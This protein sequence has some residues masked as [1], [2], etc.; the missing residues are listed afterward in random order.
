MAALTHWLQVAATLLLSDV[1]DLKA[2]AKLASGDPH[3]FNLGT[4][5][6]G[7]NICGQ[8]LRG[9]QFTGIDSAA[10]LFDDLTE[11]DK[12]YWR[13]FYKNPNAVQLLSQGREI[14]ADFEALQ[15]EAV[16]IISTIVRERYAVDRG[17]KLFRAILDNRQVGTL[18][19]FNYPVGRSATEAKAVATL[20]YVIEGHT[21]DDDAAC[22]S[23]NKREHS[24]NIF[25]QRC[26]G[27]FLVRLLA[28]LL[29]FPHKIGFARLWRFEQCD[30][31]RCDHKGIV[32]YHAQIFAV[33]AALACASPGDTHFAM[34]RHHPEIRRALVLSFVVWNEAGFGLRRHSLDGAGPTVGCSHELANNH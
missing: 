2:L 30:V 31:E 12:K 15:T 32:Q 18:V 9:M 28:V 11:L 25:C 13:Q 17:A 6:D 20:R 10:V 24:G 5:L 3:N 14:V 26:P 34:S 23:P 29:A 27:L 4:P 8:D 22:S 1:S 19:V 7:V 16:K 33:I 21:A